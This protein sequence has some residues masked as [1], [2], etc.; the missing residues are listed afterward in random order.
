[1]KVRDKI[2]LMISFVMVATVARFTS[3][4]SSVDLVTPTLL[5]M[6]FICGFGYGMVGWAIFGIVF[7][8]SILSQGAV[9]MIFI[10]GLPVTVSV[11]NFFLIEVLT[12]LTIGIL[13]YSIKRWTKKGFVIALPVVAGLVKW[14]LMFGQDFWTLVFNP[15][16][17]TGWGAYH[18]QSVIYSLSKIRDGVLWTIPVSILIIALQA[19]QHRRVTTNMLDM[20]S[21]GV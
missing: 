15:V 1:M 13:V 10:G 21:D 14:A 6:S 3:M 2:C 12:C 5:T 16:I 11:L 9:G 20:V 19:L 7:E 18:I 4:N 8:V 17:A